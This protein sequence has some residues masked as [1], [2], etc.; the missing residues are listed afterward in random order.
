MTN[1]IQ[2]WSQGQRCVVNIH[3]TVH[4]HNTTLY[5][6]LAEV[7]QCLCC[8]E[9]DVVCSDVTAAVRRC[10]VRRP[11]GGAVVQFVQ[12]VL[13]RETRLQRPGL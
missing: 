11:D 12:L 8:G 1:R 9:S 3:A 7:N 13:W 5:N 2:S 4:H 6:H 10:D